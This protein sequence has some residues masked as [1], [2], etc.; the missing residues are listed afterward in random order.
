M[1][2][3]DIIL[4]DD[5]QRETEWR[6]SID[7]DG[8]GNYVA[9]AHLYYDAAGHRTVDLAEYLDKWALDSMIAEVLRSTKAAP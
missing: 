9:A 1:I 3:A 8:E 7:S 6:V 5:A 4:H 2:S